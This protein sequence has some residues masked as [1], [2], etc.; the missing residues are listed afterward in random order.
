MKIMGI[1]D[2]SRGIL[3]FSGCPPRNPQKRSG[4]FAY[5]QDFV[6][7]WLRSFLFTNDSKNYRPTHPNPSRRNDERGALTYWQIMVMH[8]YTLGTSDMRCLQISRLADFNIKKYFLGE[9]LIQ[10][11]QESIQG[12]SKRILSQKK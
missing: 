12:D 10:K 6:S 4:I 3:V 7:P 8:A 1:S 9:T 5:F 11:N 2:K